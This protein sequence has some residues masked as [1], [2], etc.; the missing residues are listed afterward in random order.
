MARFELECLASSTG[1]VSTGRIEDRDR[2]YYGVD[3]LFTPLGV[4]DHSTESDTKM[5]DMMR[6]CVLICAYLPYVSSLF[7]IYIYTNNIHSAN[8]SSSNFFLDICVPCL[9]YFE[10]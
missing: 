6:S 4:T 3:H 9:L 10:H 1:W 5:S 8:R 7:H 2:Y